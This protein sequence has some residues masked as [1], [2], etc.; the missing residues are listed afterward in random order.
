MELVQ[1]WES[2]LRQMI[3]NNFEVILGRTWKLYYVAWACKVTETHGVQSIPDSLQMDIMRYR[4]TESISPFLLPSP[5]LKALLK[6]LL[7]NEFMRRFFKNISLLFILT[8][9][10]GNWR[11]IIWQNDSCSLGYLRF[12]ETE[13]HYSKGEG[14]NFPEMFLEK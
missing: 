12:G 5:L 6:L 14:V 13:K 11:N 2:L 8:K 1:E 10:I 4:R 7:M 9:S 3:G